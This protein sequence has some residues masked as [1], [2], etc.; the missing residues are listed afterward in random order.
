MISEF[1]KLFR[2][3]R[4]LMLS[5]VLA[6]GFVVAFKTVVDPLVLK[7]LIDDALGKRNLDHFLWIV[8]ITVVFAFG[9]R[10]LQ[11]AANLGKIRVMNALKRSRM[12]EA[13]GQFFAIPYRTINERGHG[14]FANRVLDEPGKIA[15]TATSL[16]ISLSEAFLALVSAISIC[17]VLSWQVTVALLLLVPVL[18]AISVKY[19][20]RII[21]ESE[22]E[23]E[24]GARLREGLSRCLD[25]IKLIRSFSLQDRVRGCL[26]G[27]IGA[28]LESNYQRN[29]TSQIYLT[30]SHVFLALSETVVLLVTAT[31]VFIG[32]LTVGGLL[33]YMSGFWKMMNAMMILVDRAPELSNLMAFINRSNELKDLTETTERNDIAEVAVRNLRFGYGDKPLVERLS[34]GLQPG[35]RLLVAGANGTGKS[36]LLHVISGFYSAEGQISVPSPDRISAMLAPLNFFQGSLAD[37]LDYD[38][39]TSL[40]QARID[41]MLADFGIAELLDKDP[42]YFS[43]GQKHKAYLAICLSKEADLYLLDEPLAAVDVDSKDVLMRWIERST[44]GKMLVMVMHGDEKYHGLFDR[45]LSLDGP[46]ALPLAS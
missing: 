16:A 27:S 40:E 11:M 35:Q 29:R 1:L 22:T 41:T 45:H 8:G 30:L 26:E 31:A 28:Y 37:H 15:E 12:E 17:L 39:R 7:W 14:Y 32:M 44:A 6:N 5:V 21:S 33:A 4:R 38:R 19:G 42:A 9:L 36:S 10:F 3:Q 2:Q 18:Y 13:I 34:F 23:S 25:S 20:R 43:E 46:R 24:N